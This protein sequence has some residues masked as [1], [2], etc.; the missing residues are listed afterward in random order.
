MDILFVVEVLVNSESHLEYL[1]GGFM[2]V[3]RKVLAPVDDVIVFPFMISGIRG[4]CI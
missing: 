4:L 3:W 1:E 2:I